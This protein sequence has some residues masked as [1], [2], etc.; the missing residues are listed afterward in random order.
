MVTESSLWVIRLPPPP[1]T[2]SPHPSVFGSLT[3]THLGGREGRKRISYPVT[4]AYT[5]KILLFSYSLLGNKPISGS[6]FSSFLHILPIKQ[7]KYRISIKSMKTKIIL[8][9]VNACGLAIFSNFYLHWFFSNLSF[10]E[11]DPHMDSPEGIRVKQSE[12][13]NSERY[14]WCY[15]GRNKESLRIYLVK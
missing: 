8:Y 10:F 15:T 11:R 14:C 4:K 7:Y 9:Y 5:H 1:T 3:F 6:H 13:W 2:V 12:I